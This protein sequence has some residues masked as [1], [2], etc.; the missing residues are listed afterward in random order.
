MASHSI[1]QGLGMGG[2]GWRLGAWTREEVSEAEEQG[3]SC[4]SLPARVGA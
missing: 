1:G 3:M 4:P 2:G